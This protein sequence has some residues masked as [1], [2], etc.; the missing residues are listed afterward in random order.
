MRCDAAPRYER[1]HVQVST[2]GRSGRDDGGQRNE[3]E[4]LGSLGLPSSWRR[5]VELPDK[6]STSSATPPRRLDLTSTQNE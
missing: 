2:F 3:R 6:F 4:E 5:R 1:T